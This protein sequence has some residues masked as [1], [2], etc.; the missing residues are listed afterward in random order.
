MTGLH[1]KKT[2]YFGISG[3]EAE[4]GKN[5]RA[6]RRILQGAWD[7]ARKSLSV[8]RGPEY[9]KSAMFRNSRWF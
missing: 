4:R 1:D 8:N 2:A 9:Y 6:V 7:S 5:S 3:N